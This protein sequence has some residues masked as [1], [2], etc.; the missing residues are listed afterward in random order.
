MKGYY[1]LTFAI[2][3]EV[4]GTTM[5]KLSDGFTNLL[6]SVAFGAG[7]VSAFYFLSVSLKQIPLSLAYAIWSGAGTVLTAIIGI[8]I[9]Q[10]AFTFLSAVGIILIVGGIALLN[11]S[12]SEKK[13]KLTASS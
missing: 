4:F 7:F 12:S 9:W 10:E 3:C 1:A 6:P 2:V 8:I 11:A 13:K 5:L